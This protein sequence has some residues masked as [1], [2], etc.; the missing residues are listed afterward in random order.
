VNARG[1]I[2]AAPAS[3]S[4]KTTLVAGLLR[5]LTLRGLRASAAKLGP[6]YIDPAF[7]A[8][9]AGG[10]CLNIDLWAMRPETVS[11]LLERL[12]HGKELAIVEGAMGLFDGAADGQGSAA[13]FAAFCGWPVILVIDAH[14]QAQ[15]VAALLS[16]FARH[17]A[18]VQIAGVIFNRVGGASHQAALRRAVEPLGIPVLGAVPRKADLVLPERHLGLVQAMEHADLEDFLDLLADN[19]TERVSVER[20]VD[21]ARPA[22]FEPVTSPQALLP[23]LGQRIAVARD[24]AFAFLYAGQIES[25]REAGVELEFFSPLC[26]EQPSDECDAVYLPGGYPELHAGQLAASEG[27]LTGLRWAAARGATVFGE[28]GGYM[29]LGAGLIDEDGKRHAMAGLLPLESSFVE[30]RLH[31]GYRQA[32]TLADCPLGT[33][34]AVFRGHEFHYAHVLE[35][36]PGEPLFECS[37]ALGQALG[38]S[39]RRH[40]SV[41]GSF[42]HL[43]DRQD[44]GE[45]TARPS[46]VV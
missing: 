40:G 33:H 18:D 35:E 14:G 12:L 28:C 22:R 19:L 44:E 26:D 10:S 43:I 38:K 16:G 9:A 15:S 29:T 32:K 5:L 13:D 8:A 37:D 1:L 4:G 46:A 27:F 41:A 20:L 3:G 31:L 6:D 7:H 11:S 42:I 21:I 45:P 30:P 25:W 34:G 36:G 17:R 24:A 39:G 23:P 2:F